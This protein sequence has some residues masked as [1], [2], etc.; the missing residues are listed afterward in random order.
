MNKEK[1]KRA[2]DFIP[3]IILLVYA[4]MLSWTLITTNYA[5]VW[6][7]VAGLIVLPITLLGFYRQHRMGVLFLGMTLLLGLFG[8]LS[9]SLG[10]TRATVSLSIND[11]RIEFWGQP[12]F[13]LWL[14]LHFILSGRYY[15]G[16]LSKKYW[17]DLTLK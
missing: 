4:I 16:V 2:S 1:L 13:F 6:R 5:F 3:L 17:Q 15:V 9:Y 8:L 10:L 12:I 11:F 7:N 14:V